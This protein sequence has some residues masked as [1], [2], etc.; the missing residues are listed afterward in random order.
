MGL[1]LLR[2]VMNRNTYLGGIYIEMTVNAL[3][4][5]EIVKGDHVKWKPG[6]DLQQS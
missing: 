4:V 6:K 5:D 1:E 2:E 3:G